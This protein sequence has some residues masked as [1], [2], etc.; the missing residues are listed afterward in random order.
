M[1][2]EN[3]GIMK[4][5]TKKQVFWDGSVS[6]STCHTLVRTWVQIPSTNIKQARCS[7]RYRKITGVHL[8]PSLLHSQWWT[9]KEEGGEWSSRIPSISF[10]LCLCTPD[11]HTHTQHT[12]S[13][14]KIKE[15]FGMLKLFFMRIVV[16]G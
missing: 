5:I 11:V 4:I 1:L 2:S 10:G 16:L 15:W 6:K 13:M 14:L 8:S 12:Q 7:H 3:I 9:W